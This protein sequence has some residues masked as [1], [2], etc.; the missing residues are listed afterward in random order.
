MPERSSLIDSLAAMR[1]AFDAAFA[2]AR[3]IT[4]RPSTDLLEVRIG[5]RPYALLMTELAAVRP[6]AS[7]TRVP[8]SAFALIGLTQVGLRLVPVYDLRL[9]L[10]HEADT[11]PGCFVVTAGEPAV[12]MAVD[13]Y[14]RHQRVPNDRV[15]VGDAREAGTMVNGAVVDV[16]GSPRP[17][18]SL[19]AVLES[20][21]ARVT[22]D[23]S[24]GMVR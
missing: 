21:R 19:H 1:E 22:G 10:G 20:I 3:D 6:T 14:E 4:Q 24:K 8:T 16:D 15:S 13:A 7:L 2:R 12:A 11:P 5:G 17:I 9:L 23:S 18:V